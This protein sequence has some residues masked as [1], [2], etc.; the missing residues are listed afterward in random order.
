MPSFF[1]N[2]VVLVLGLG[3][4][5]AAGPVVEWFIDAKSWR[6]RAYVLSACIIVMAWGYS[7]IPA[8][9]IPESWILAI[10]LV[11][12][13]STD[14]LQLRLPSAIT[15]P[16][17]GVGLVLSSEDFSP[18]FGDRAIGA[19]I[20]YLVISVIAHTYRKLSG[21]EGIGLGDAKLF[22]AAGAWLGWTALP[23]VLLLASIGGLLWG[24]VRF[25]VNKATLYAPLPFG[26][27]LA[28]AFWLVWL[29]GTL[30][31]W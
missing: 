12:L 29:Y 8:P 1:Y 20:G 2:S 13:A 4:A 18:T 30:T 28:A 27:P 7:A 24:I 11:I 9:L 10:G 3:A 15:L 14:L 25:L 19:C 6:L 5:V 26:V 23:S 31:I 21:R 17:L 16:L 22:A